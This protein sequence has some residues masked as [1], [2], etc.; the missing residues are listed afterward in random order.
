MYYIHYTHI[1][2]ITETEKHWQTGKRCVVRDTIHTVTDSVNVY[3]AVYICVQMFRTFIYNYGEYLGGIVKQTINRFF[4]T[5]LISI[6]FF[7]YVY[8]DCEIFDTKWIRHIPDSVSIQFK[9]KRNPIRIT[10]LNRDITV[11]SFLF[12][13]RWIRF[14]RAM[15]LCVSTNECEKNINQRYREKN[16]CWSTNNEKECFL[17]YRKKVPKTNTLSAVSVFPHVCAEQHQKFI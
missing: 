8:S 17:Y 13:Q 1:Y 9:W 14:M 5:I 15:W 4:S 11:Y 10:R 12:K 7:F 6:V 2:I 3:V 16:R